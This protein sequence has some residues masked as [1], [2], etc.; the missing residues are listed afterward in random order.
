MWHTLMD[1][2]NQ[3]RLEAGANRPAL[4]S[5]PLEERPGLLGDQWN[6]EDDDEGRQNRDQIEQALGAD[7]GRH[8]PR[9][10]RPRGPHLPVIGGDGGDGE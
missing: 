7:R 4:A 5:V 8:F 9:E 2:E 10:F 6:G 1:G 3:Q